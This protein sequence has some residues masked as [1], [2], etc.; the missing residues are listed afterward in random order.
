MCCSL[1]RGCTVGLGKRCQNLPASKHHPRRP[2]TA[3]NNRAKSRSVVAAINEI[4]LKRIS[5][6]QPER[7]TAKAR[8]ISR[9]EIKNE[10]FISFDSIVRAREVGIETGWWW[11]TD[12]LT[13]WL[14]PLDVWGGIWMNVHFFLAPSS[15]RLAWSPAV[16]FNTTGLEG[17]CPAEGNHL[18]CSSDWSLLLTSNLWF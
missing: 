6:P 17:W 1:S 7:W 9:T 8:G 16:R 12:W 15:N 5:S 11:L 2:A 4:P 14:G 18:K 3:G 13:D 10:T